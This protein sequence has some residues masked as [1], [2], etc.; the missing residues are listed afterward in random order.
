MKLIVFGATGRTGVQL[1]RELL[2][3][4]HE[5]TAIVREPNQFKKTDIVDE[6]LQTKLKIK[7]GDVLNPSTLQTVMIGKDAVISLLGVNHRNPTT[8]YSEG[9]G[10]IINEM[11]NCGVKRLICLS[12]ET[13][14]SKQEASFIQRIIIRVLWKIFFNLYDDMRRMEQKVFL[15]ELDWTI[16]RLPRLTNGLQ[17]GRYRISINQSVPNGKGYISRANL[18][19]CLAA[20]LNN[21]DLLNSI[22]YISS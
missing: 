15:S 7:K 21:P 19:E 10:H 6:I 16:V 12:A 22:V 17:T 2:V 13:L 18:A 5:V 14:K 1:L 4:G 8:V 11:K 3:D 20:Q 9:I